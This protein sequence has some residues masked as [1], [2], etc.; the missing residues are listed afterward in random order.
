MDLTAYG[1]GASGTLLAADLELQ[2]YQLLLSNVAQGDWVLDS[3]QL[4]TLKGIANQCPDIGA[5]GV[6][7][8]RAVLSAYQSTS[9]N[10]SL[11]CSVKQLIA[12]PGNT[13]IRS[14]QVAELKVF[15]NPAQAQVTLQWAT[16]ASQLHVYSATGKLIVQHPLEMAA[17]NFELSLEGYAK[18]LYFLT[19][20]LHDGRYSTIKLIKQ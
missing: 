12:Q 1:Q 6:L 2:V 5:P 19:L 15:P 14:E 10:D 18:G 16:D 3:L 17:R 11:L 13:T 8:A 4:D 7:H 9:Y 20:R